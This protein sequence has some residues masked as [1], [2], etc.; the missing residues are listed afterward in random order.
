MDARITNL[1]ARNSYLNQVLFELR[2]T[3]V[4]QDRMRF[5]ANMEKVGEILAYEM[6]R[7]F[8]Y[9]KQHV[10][11]PLG[12]LDMDLLASQPV[13]VSILRAGI[14][15]HQGFLR[16]M[17][18]AD[19]G[20]ISAFRHHTRGNEFIVKVE[21]LALP[22]ITGRTVVLVDPMIATGKSIVLA[23]QA[24]LEQGHPEQIFIGAAVASEEGLEYVLRH[25]PKARILVA[26]VDHELTAKAY[27]V[28]G[29]GDAG[30]L[31]FGP[32]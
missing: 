31:A 11:T 28:P 3:E 8:P 15:F 32:K 6:S 21:Y 25:I 26:A 1:G 12:E 18:R 27:I 20:F 22:E 29:L 10:T 23:Y 19:N 7:E 30:D 13:L 16:L 5:R 14:P 2:D 4:Q 17:D 24:L 9:E